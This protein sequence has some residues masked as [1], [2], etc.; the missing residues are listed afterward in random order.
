ME[1]IFSFF[2]LWEEITTPF[3]NRLSSSLGVS[4]PTDICSLV[5]LLAI[6]LTAYGLI[7]LIFRPR[8]SREA[9]K[10]QIKPVV[11]NNTKQGVIAPIAKF[12]VPSHRYDDPAF[13]TK[14]VA[15]I[16]DMNLIV[17]SVDALQYL[18]KLLR[19]LLAQEQTSS[20]VMTMANTLFYQTNQLIDWLN[21]PGNAQ[22]PGYDPLNLFIIAEETG[23][24]DAL[25]KL[26]REDMEDMEK[27]VEMKTPGTYTTAE[28]CVIGD[29]IF[30]GGCGAELISDERSQKKEL[31][32]AI[33]SPY[34]P[35][36]NAPIPKGYD[37][38]PKC[39]QKKER[40]EEGSM[41]EEKASEKMG[42]TQN[43]DV[44][45]CPMC[46]KEAAEDDIFCGQCGRRLKELDPDQPPPTDET[47]DYT[48]PPSP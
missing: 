7:Y 21:E 38:C 11:V 39:R 40:K 29:G 13:L 28:L 15:R 37:F 41:G 32:T 43:P 17:S 36:C 16:E 18:H 23:S 3:I 46:Q 44:R 10:R 48:M 14:R 31:G 24:W 20:E 1:T 30:C 33:S 22:K 27:E 19:N 25:L 6:V 9:R 8:P 35:Q 5:L 12:Q 2:D 45:K 4:L 34:C 47:S 26:A 42:S